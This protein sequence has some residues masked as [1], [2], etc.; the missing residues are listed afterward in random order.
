MSMK[1]SP[2]SGTR[3][4]QLFLVI[5]RFGGPVE[6]VNVTTRDKIWPDQQAQR[7]RPASLGGRGL[8]SG[9]FMPKIS[10]K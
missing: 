9:V 2:T 5:H 6:R 3:L 8:H 10:P 7:M 4:W 1:A